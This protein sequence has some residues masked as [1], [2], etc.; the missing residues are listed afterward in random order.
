ME[1]KRVRIVDRSNWGRYG[2]YPWIRS[3]LAAWNC[4]YCGE[5]MGE[6][7]PYSFCEDGERYVCDVWTNPCGHV[8]AYSELTIIND[9]QE[10]K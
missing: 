5:V 9:V 1:V 7:R 6:P 3:V 10:N 4:P 2:P 8:V